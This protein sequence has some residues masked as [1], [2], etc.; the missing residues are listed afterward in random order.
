M[1]IKSM[2]DLDF[3]KLTMANVV[4]HRY[5]T[6]RVA[7]KFVCRTKGADLLPYMEDIR[8]EIMDLSMLALTNE[9]F[10]YLSTIRFLDPA[11]VQF[12][13]N[14]RLDPKK[15]VKLFND[16]S[17][18]G[19][20]IEGSWLQTIWY[21][22]MLLAIVNEIYFRDKMPKPEAMKAAADRLEPKLTMLEQNPGIKLSEFGTR[23]RHSFEVQDMVVGKMKGLANFTGTSN[24]FLA[25]KHN[26]KP[27]G[28]QAHEFFMAHQAIVRVQ[29]S[30]QTALRV[31][32]EDFDGDLGIA[33][34]DTI[35]MDTFLLDFTR[36]YAK[37]FDGC[38]HDSGDPI[39]WGEKLI[40]HYKQ[41]G[42]DPTTKTAVFSDGLNIPKTKELYEYFKGRINV[43]FGV[44]TDLTNDVG[45]PALNIVIKMTDCNGQ[46]VAKISDNPGKNICSSPV[47][48]NFLKACFGLTE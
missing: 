30:Q 43:A 24:V 46:P 2:L 6:A 21:E 26:V 3:Y 37:L 19:I 18:L 11:F 1:I 48:V 8:R 41:L 27:I 31:W 42:I 33:L 45:M 32:A 9:E 20:T 34:T 10:K 17:N 28:T 23:R 7:Y 14:L 40:K 12:L 47:Y 22:T 15:E 13:S 25:M 36:F 38:R 44:G 29:D 35:N 4:F 5:P 16:G 39:V